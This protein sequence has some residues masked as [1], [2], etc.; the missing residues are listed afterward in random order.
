MKI[1]EV[2]EKCGITVNEEQKESLIKTCSE[3]VISVAESEKRVKK[4]QDELDATSEKLTNTEETLKGFDGVDVEGFKKTIADLQ[5]DNEKKDKEYKEQLEKRD[6]SDAVNKRVADIKFSSKS[7]KKSFIADLMENPLQMR[8]G[9]ILG[10]DDYLTKVKT[11]DPDSFISEDSGSAGKFTK[12]NE[13]GAG[14][15]LSNDNALR[16]AMGL[17]IKEE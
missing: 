5:A 9:D 14:A 3:E 10:F 1:L 2:L 6:Y 4:V 15:T 13:G 17:K 7:A 12:P 16:K 11:D 8:D